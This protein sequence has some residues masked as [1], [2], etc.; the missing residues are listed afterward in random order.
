MNLRKQHVYTRIAERVLGHELPP[1]AVVHH[2]N[3]DETDDRPGNLVICEN[4]VYHMFLHQRQR[5]YEATGNPDSR[6]CAF[7]GNYDDAANLYKQKH[8]YRHVECARKY[9]QEWKRKYR[10]ANDGKHYISA[11]RERTNWVDPRASRKQR[12]R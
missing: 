8:S 5:A 3:G 1:Q 2:V 9:N 10:E 4:N 12:E 6:K 7:C 11:W